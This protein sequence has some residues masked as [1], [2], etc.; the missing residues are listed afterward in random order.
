VEVGLGGGGVAGG[1]AG[2]QPRAGEAGRE[3]AEA[4]GAHQE[5]SGVEAGEA[6]RQGVAGGAGTLAGQALRSGTVLEVG[7]GAG[8]VASGPQYVEP[9]VTGSALRSVGRKAAETSPIAH[10]T[11]CTVDHGQ[12]RA[13]VGDAARPLQQ[14]PSL[15]RSASAAVHAVLAGR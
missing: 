12:P 2:A 1:A 5:E 11:V 4:G 9:A 6:D 8:S 10:S 3:A 13:A 14:Q 7:A 15:A